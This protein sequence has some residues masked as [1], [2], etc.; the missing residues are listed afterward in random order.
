MSSQLQKACQAG[1]TQE[2]A[3]FCAAILSEVTFSLNADEGF[4]EQVFDQGLSLF[5]EPR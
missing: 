2:T 5:D 3:V 1:K 4:R